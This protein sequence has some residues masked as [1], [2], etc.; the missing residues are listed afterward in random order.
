MAAG[1]I[2]YRYKLVKEPSIKQVLENQ[3]DQKPI[4]AKKLIV[5][6][7]GLYSKYKII[8]I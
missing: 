4:T 2:S 8:N 7:N 6:I 3:E 5:I 1:I